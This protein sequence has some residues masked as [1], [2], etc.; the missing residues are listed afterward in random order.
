[1]GATVKR[2]DV[3]Q[4]VLVAITAA[5]FGSGMAILVNTGFKSDDVFAFGGA[6]VGAAGTVAGAAWLTDRAV[7]KEKREEQS[8]VRAELETVLSAAEK[9]YPLFP[10]DE[11]WTDGWRAALHELVEVARGAQ[12][13]LE[14]VITHA[15]T[16]NFHQRESV[17]DARARIGF[18]VDFYNDVF[19]GPYDEDPMD[20]RSWPGTIADMIDGVAGAL[21]TFRKV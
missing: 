19:S 12:R 10:H 4:S 9:A 3:I 5:G 2:D 17:K 15:K 8:L 21:T 13:F 7:T 18:F 11:P 1:M 20:E 6:I 16:L 14:E